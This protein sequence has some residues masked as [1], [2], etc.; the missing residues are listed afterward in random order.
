[1]RLWLIPM[2]Y[3]GASVALG[4]ALPR[5]EQT[6]LPSLTVGLSVASAQAFLSGSA[7]SADSAA[8]PL[9]ERPGTVAACNDPSPRSYRLPTTPKNAYHSVGA[10]YPF[11]A[12]GQ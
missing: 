11:I 2:I 5:V 9:S 3:V 7:V 1:M 4:L 10:G 8:R 6:F 12:A